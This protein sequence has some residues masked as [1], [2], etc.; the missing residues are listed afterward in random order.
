MAKKDNFAKGKIGEQ[1]ACSYLKNKGYQIIETNFQNRFGEIDLICA[2]GKKIFFVEVKLKIGDD[3]G[4]PEEMINKRKIYQLEKMAQ[5][6]L[7]ER[8]ILDYSS[9]QLDAVCIVLNKSL[10]LTRIS[11]YPNI[12]MEV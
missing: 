4:S 8:N 5:I 1:I 7:Q 3:F 11:H 10:K 9:L 12:K 2:K 6:F